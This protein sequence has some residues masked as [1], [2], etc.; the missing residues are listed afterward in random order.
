MR[1]EPIRVS[2]EKTGN[3]VSMRSTVGTI[4]IITDHPSNCNSADQCDYAAWYFLPVSMRLNR[5]LHIV[6]SGTPTTKRNWQ[7]LSEIWQSWLPGHFYASQL[8]FEHQ[9]TI[10]K[11]RNSSLPDLMFFS[12]G[13]DAAYLG[14]Q[15][16]EE[17]KSQHLLTVQGMD[18]S[19]DDQRRFDALISKTESFAQKLSDTRIVVKS[20][21]YQLY[22]KFGVNLHRHHLSH[23]FALAGASFFHSRFYSNVFLA[24]D[25]P[26]AAQFSFFPWGTNVITNSFFD[27]GSF[28]IIETSQGVSRIEKLELVRTSKMAMHSLAFCWNRKIQPQNCGV[29]EKCLRTKLLGLAKFGAVLDIFLDRSIPPNWA[30][31]LNYR[32]REGFFILQEILIIAQKSGNSE[33]FPDFDHVVDRIF[34]FHRRLRQITRY[35]PA[36]LTPEI[37]ARLTSRFL[38]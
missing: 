9:E 30:E 11:V 24:D 3:G 1:L 22:N 23:I 32:T 5:P 13:L 34:R 20:N 29:C 31:I 27:D 21:A 2:I 15:R 17:N 14:L 12:G 36:F 18:Y 28:K 33:L 6:G 37:V 4:D 35:W 8:S 16:L 25:E 38:R 7:K 26:L 19:L 10:A